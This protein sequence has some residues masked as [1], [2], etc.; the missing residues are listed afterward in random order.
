MGV[1][2]VRFFVIFTSFESYDLSQLVEG[3][4]SAGQIVRSGQGDL[5]GVE[6][7]QMPPC[8]MRVLADAHELLLA[9]LAQLRECQESDGV[10]LVVSHAVIFQRALHNEKDSLVEANDA[11]AWEPVRSSSYTTLAGSISSDVVA[12]G[13]VDANASGSFLLSMR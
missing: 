13:H 7:A 6:S 4:W 3:F 2:L 8:Q 10:D 12:V 9:P 5:N 11:E 1:L